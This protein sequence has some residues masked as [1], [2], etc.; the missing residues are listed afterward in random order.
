[1]ST[2]SSICDL[3]MQICLLIPTVSYVLK[4]EHLKLRLL[5]IYNIISKY[6][7]E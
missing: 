7:L 4:D 5:D 1:M 2:P 6:T 3:H